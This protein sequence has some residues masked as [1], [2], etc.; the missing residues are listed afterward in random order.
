MN[1][2]ASPYHMIQ[3]VDHRSYRVWIF[4]MY[5]ILYNY[6]KKNYDSGLEYE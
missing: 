4:Q 5:K 3:G 2:G 1:I 6:K